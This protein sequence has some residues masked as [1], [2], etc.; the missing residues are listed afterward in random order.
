MLS[1]LLCYISRSSGHR[2]R[3]PNINIREIIWLGNQLTYAVPWPHIARPN[4]HKSQKIPQQITGGGNGKT[5][6]SY[7]E[8][9]ADCINPLT[10]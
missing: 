7:M 10:I 5:Y 2:H 8:T 1:T 9:I 4:L 6:G 3:N